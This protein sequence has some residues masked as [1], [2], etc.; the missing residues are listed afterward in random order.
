[1]WE[2][3]DRFLYIALPRIKDFRGIDSN[4]DGHGNITIGVKENIIFPEIDYNDIDKIRGL[5]ISIKFSSNTDKSS[6]FILTNMN[7]PLKFL[8]LKSL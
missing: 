2:F 3:L 6:K 7:F 4:F 1:M 8:K 5:N